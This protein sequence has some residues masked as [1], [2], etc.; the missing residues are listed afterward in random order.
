M[1]TKN[2][3]RNKVNYED[4]FA[5]QIP[6]LGSEGQQALREKSIFIAA[7]GGLGTSVALFLARA[8]IK[9]ICQADPQVIEPD[10]LNRI[11]AGERHLGRQKVNAVKEY[12]LCFDQLRS[13][14]EMI[15]IPLP[16]PVEHEHVRPYLEKAD[17]IVACPNSLTA[18]RYLARYAVEHGKTLL[19]VGFG[20]SPGDYM[21]GELSLYRPRQPEMACPACISLPAPEQADIAPDPLFYPPLAILAALTVHVL[22]AEI[23]NFDRQGDTRPNYFFYDGYAHELHGMRV[24]RSLDCTICGSPQA[25]HVPLVQ[26]ALHEEG[27]P[28]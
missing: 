10:N 20:C 25:G 17:V 5:A 15:Y 21:T 4:R 28:S 9:H 18:R 16:F 8:G 24:A 19:N 11:S 3:P 7:A 26:G 14:R 2:E 27:N 23:T 6:I 13:D 12:L 1:K 22:V